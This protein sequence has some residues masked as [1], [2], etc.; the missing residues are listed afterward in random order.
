MEDFARMIN[1]YSFLILYLFPLSIFAENSW[2]PDWRE[3]S[4]KVFYGE[5]RNLETKFETR[6]EVSAEC[7]YPHFDEKSLLIDYVNKKL[8]IGAVNLFEEFIEYEKS[9]QEEYNNDFGGCYL[10]YKLIPAYCLPHLISVYGS[11]SQSRDCPHG[12]THHEGRNFWQNGNT[13]VEINIQDLFIKES[14]WCN[15]LLNYCDQHFKATR[16]GYYAC[17]DFTPE[18]ETDDLEIFI[19]TERGLMIIFQSY[20]V[21]GWADGPD[22]ITIPYLDLKTFIDPDGPLKEIF[23]T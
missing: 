8:E 7:T 22:M 6:V 18:L 16:H 20:R 3:D 17:E 23:K 2:I 12:W 4:T 21:G 19:L 1:K 9:T 13:I 5:W 15:F 14:D 11:E 10:S